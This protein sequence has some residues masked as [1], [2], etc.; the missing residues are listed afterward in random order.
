MFDPASKRP[1][2]SGVYNS[3]TKKISFY[4]LYIPK[5]G[6][7]F[8]NIEE[9]KKELKS[10]IENNSDGGIVISDYKNHVLSFHLSHNDDVYDIPVDPIHLS[11]MHDIN[12]AKK[13][14]ARAIKSMLGEE[15]KI[16][17]KV[18]ARASVVYA[19]LQRSGLIYNYTKMYPI[20]DMETYSGRSRASGFSAQG[21]EK[22]ALIHNINEDPVFIQFDWIAADIRMAAIMSQDGKLNESFT[23][24]DPYEYVANHFNEGVEDDKLTRDEMKIELLSS[25]Y[26]MNNFSPVFD[27]YTGLRKWIDESAQR[28]KDDGYIESILGRRFYTGDIFGKPRTE[29]SAFN[30]AIQGSVASAM[31]NVLS[32][33]HKIFPNNILLETHDALIVTSENNPR[34]IQDKISIVSKI[35]RWPFFGI[36]DDNPEF[37]LVVSIGKKCGEWRIQKR[38][39]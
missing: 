15:P 2:I 35:M 25:I 10:I 37:P 32:E 14:L 29:K 1:L 28:L 23:V 6:K 30:A 33:T 18:K 3:D 19:H 8:Y 31:Q 17:H 26:S 5:S 36:L 11:S 22:D 16:W 4:T 38:Y 34:S 39:G 24:S 7:S 13:M 27:F 12:D 20:W 21:L 9:T